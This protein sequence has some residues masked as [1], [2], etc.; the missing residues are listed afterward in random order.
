M[1]EVDISLIFISFLEIMWTVVLHDINV[2]N[3]HDKMHVMFTEDQ[4]LI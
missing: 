3:K 2:C 4:N 1:E